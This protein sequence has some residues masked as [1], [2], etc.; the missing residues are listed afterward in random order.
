[1]FQ[2]KKRLTLAISTLLL[3]A[4]ASSL[5]AMAQGVPDGDTV[6][7]NEI[8]EL[9]PVDVDVEVID[10]VARDAEGYA[11]PEGGPSGLYR[12]IADKQDKWGETVD[13]DDQGN[14]TVNP[15]DGNHGHQVALEKQRRNLERKL[16]KEGIEFGAPDEDV[17]IQPVDDVST[18]GGDE[19]G[20]AKMELFEGEGGEP[21]IELPELTGEELSRLA[22]DVDGEPYPEGGPKGLYKAIV[23]KQDKLGERVEIDEAEDVKTVEQDGSGNGGLGNA[24]G[25]LRAN[26]ER[27][28]DKL[29]LLEDKPDTLPEGDL[30]GIEAV[31]LGVKERGKSGKTERV[32]ITGKSQ[33]PARASKVEKVQKVDK[34]QRVEKAARIERFQKP[35]KV[36]RV[37]KPEKPV[38]VSRVQRPEKVERFSKPE[39]PQKPQKPEKPGKPERPR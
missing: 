31:T 7:E 2:S 15:G 11:Y 35:E 38:K 18:T 33:K 25:R 1:M 16:N 8:P 17:E 28:L 22:H 14:R 9:E 23:D 20:I 3:A 13:V 19:Q 29:G 27:K 39:K 4:S 32:V 36:T 34:P 10:G 6:P 37:E 24:L 26:L 12:S 21:E 5:P 30:D